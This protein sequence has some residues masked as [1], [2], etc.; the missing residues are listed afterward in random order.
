MMEELG[1][2]ASYLEEYDDDLG[3]DVDAISFR[4]QK[5]LKNERYKQDTDERKLLSHW[6]MCVVSIWLFLVLL[7]LSMNNLL[8]LNLSDTVVCMLLGTTTI[9]ILGLA[10]IVLK[11][12][13]ESKS[14]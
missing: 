12:L 7:I 9:N 2:K 3:W 6:V 11:G 13:F 4:E 1:F 5:K 10:Y 14:R 8:H